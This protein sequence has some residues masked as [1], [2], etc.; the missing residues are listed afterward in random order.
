MRR[1]EFI[2]LFCGAGAWPFAA[3][4]Q[5]SPG[6]WRIGFLAGGERPMNFEGTAYGAF[7]RGMREAGYL[8]NR[9][10]SVE[11]RF[12]EGRFELFPSLAE[13]TWRFAAHMSAF[14]PKRTSPP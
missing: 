11:W 5:Q 14:D 10:F 7:L 1:R 12:A 9:D 6:P 8:E 3:S 13:R 4:A 2:R